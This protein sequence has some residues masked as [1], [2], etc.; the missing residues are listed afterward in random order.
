MLNQRTLFNYTKNI[1]AYFSASLIPMLLNLVSNPFISMNMEPEDYAIVGYYSSFTT[2]LQPLINFYMLHYY[3]KRFYELDEEGRRILRSTLMK[4]LIWFS[5]LLT[6][7]SIV[8]VI[9]YIVLFNKETSMP[10]FPYVIMTM[11][12]LPLSGIMSLTTTDYRMSRQ[13]TEFFKLS[14]SN[15]V[16]LVVLNVFFVVIIKWG[17][18]GK[19]LAPIVTSL[20]FFLYCLY[21]YRDLIRIPFNWDT[22]KRM[23][24]FCWPLTI[25]AMLGF[26]SNGYDRV[27]LERLGNTKELGYYCVGIQIAAYVN[28]FKT[29]IGSTFQPDVFQSI[30]RR[31]WKKLFQVT[32][33]Q[34]F[35]QV[36]IVA[37]FILFAPFIIRIL[38]A[39]RYMMSVDYTRILVFSS[40][41]G[42][43]YFSLSQIT[44]GLGYTKIMLINKI[45]SSI[46]MIAL[47]GILINK[48]QFMGAAWGQVLSYVVFLVGNAFLLFISISYNKKR[49]VVKNT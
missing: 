49:N 17:A 13:A 38:T 11:L 7:L 22:F 15:G 40:L 8:G 16:T 5:G 26:F 20:V 34:V 36:C 14:V 25:A 32:F 39:G 6:L 12:P 1:G 18:F 23:L 33:V 35:V 43:L 19:M 21:Q 37:V 4:S 41:T 48:Y 30:V 47:F 9:I 24:L 3:T 42:M 28:V 44:I 10:L 27:L 2:L 45:V 46:A 31:D 29:A